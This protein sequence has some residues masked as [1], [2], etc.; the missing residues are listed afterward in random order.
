MKTIKFTPY[1]RVNSLNGRYPG[2]VY[3]TTNYEMFSFASYNRANKNGFVDKKVKEFFDLLVDGKFFGEL[4]EIKVNVKGLVWEGNNRLRAFIKYYEETGKKL[5]IRFLIYSSPLVNNVSDEEILKILIK[6]N[7]VRSEWKTM[8]IFNSALKVKAPL[9]IAIGRVI[10]KLC[11]KYDFITPRN[12]QP[13]KVV[14]IIEQNVQYLHGNKLS[15]DDYSNLEWVSKMESE[16]FKS[17]LRFAMDILE[18]L[19]SN[20]DNCPSE[21]RE[22]LKDVMTAV[23]SDRI[24][25]SK[26]WSYI[27]KK[28]FA[29]TN[30]SQRKDTIDAINASTIKVE[31]WV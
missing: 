22:V 19:Y 27:R 21:P 2:V 15:F 26:V 10:S 12:F 17:D 11:E 6:F 30:K 20:R 29:G 24:T 5:P 7:G 4:Q 3:E 28:G 14:G 23:S 31:K 13:S 16:S 1:Q 25:K 18:L 8:E 9:A